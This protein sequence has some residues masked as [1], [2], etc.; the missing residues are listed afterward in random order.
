MVLSLE[1]IQ[2]IQITIESLSTQDL[3]KTQ[4]ELRIESKTELNA[5]KY[6]FSKCVLAVIKGVFQLEDFII[7][8]VKNHMTCYK[9]NSFHWLK[10]QHT[11]NVSP[12]EMRGIPVSQSVPCNMHVIIM[13]ITCM[14][15]IPL[16]FQ[17][18]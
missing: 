7:S 15:E 10:L 13:G 6:I 9:F 11:A 16:I 14:P 5:Q 3:H 4:N 17:F 1:L 12:I 18:R 2:S 8:S